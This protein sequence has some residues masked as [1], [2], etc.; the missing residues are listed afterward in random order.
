M[1]TKSAWM[2]VCIVVLLSATCL[3][4]QGAHQCVR[5]TVAPN[6]E[7]RQDLDRV[8]TDLYNRSSSF[9]AQYDRLAAAQNLRV[10]VRLNHSLPSTCRALTR[11]WR[12][13]REIRAD[14]QVPPSHALVELLA[15]E[16]EHIVEQIE[17][18]N[19]RKLSRIRGSG[20]REL[21]D[22][23]FESDRAI[24]AGRLVAE[25]ANRQP[26]APAAD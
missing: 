18:L 25:E 6:I 21:D 24:K 4:A 20:V 19:L 2:N 9:K 15:H 23:L 16:F 8:V 5:S 12:R 7:L 1:W 22:D 10:V 17:G 14:V 11:I 26:K 3:A 13:G